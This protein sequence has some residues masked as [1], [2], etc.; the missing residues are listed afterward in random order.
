MSNDIKNY[1]AESSNS[2]V[3]CAIRNILSDPVFEAFLERE[4]GALDTMTHKEKEQYKAEIAKLSDRLK[5]ERRLGTE[6]ADELQGTTFNLSLS[7]IMNRCAEHEGEPGHIP[8]EVLDRIGRYVYDRLFPDGLSHPD[9]PNRPAPDENV[10]D[11]DTN[12]APKRPAY[13]VPMV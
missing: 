13:D 12:T 1:F 2:P 7:A 9:S 10:R 11:S 6:A 3:D 5:A 4:L 8:Q